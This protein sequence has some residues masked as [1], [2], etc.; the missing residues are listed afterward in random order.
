LV[1]P[2]LFL[3]IVPKCG[4]CVVVWAAA[5]AGVRVEL[6]GSTPSWSILASEM[7]RRLCLPV[8]A[9]EGLALLLVASVTFFLWKLLSRIGGPHP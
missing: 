7:E 4:M 1:S 9:T 3:A 8:A 2:P 5:L 6:C